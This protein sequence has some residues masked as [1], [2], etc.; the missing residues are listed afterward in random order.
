MLAGIFSGHAQDLGGFPFPKRG[1]GVRGYTLRSE[2]EADLAFQIV[3]PAHCMLFRAG[4]DD[5]F[6]VDAIFPGR[7][8]LDFSHDSV[9]RMRR[10]EVRPIRSLRAISSFRHAGPMQVLNLS[11]LKPSSNRPA[12]TFAI[13]PRL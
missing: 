4:I 5:R 12:K 11:D 7:I 1:D 6:V 10:T 13:P 2:W 8:S 9:A 3:V